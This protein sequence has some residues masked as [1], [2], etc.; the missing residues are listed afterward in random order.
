MLFAQF[1]DSFGF[2]VVMGLFLLGVNRTVKMISGSPVGRT[3]V[4]KGAGYLIRQLF[5]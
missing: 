5:K 3:A 2:A 1:G 4:N